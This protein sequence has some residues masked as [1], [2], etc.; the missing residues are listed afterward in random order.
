M[1]DKRKLLMER[2]RPGRMGVNLPSLD[3]PPQDPPPEGL[4]RKELDLPEV[5][6]PEVV[7]YFTNLSQLN[8]SIDTH[9]YPLGSCTMKYNPKVNDELASLPGFAS[10]HPLQPVETVQG[11][12]RLLYQ[13]QEILA[14]ITGMDGTSLAPLA[15]AHGEWCGML[16]FRA[17]HHS[18]GEP[19][20]KKIVIPDSAHGTNPASAAMGGYDVVSVALDSRGNMDL[21][22]LEEAATPDLAGLM[23]TL[24]NTLGLFNSGIL[25]V[26]D[27]VHRAGGLV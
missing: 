22:A 21:K 2:S 14:E 23:I 18:R 11:A 17:Y 25:E 13:L 5:T 3:V 16:M 24:P 8:F 6:E 20:R 19:D 4:L 9:F 7:R 1:Q 26:C 15:G 27:I 10:I 12:L